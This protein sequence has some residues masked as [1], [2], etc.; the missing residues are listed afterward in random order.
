[1]KIRVVCSCF[2][3]QMESGTLITW[4]FQLTALPTT[5]KSIKNANLCFGLLGWV[6]CWVYKMCQPRVW[7]ICALHATATV[8]GTALPQKKK[9]DGFVSGFVQ[10]TNC[11]LSCI[12]TI[13]IYRCF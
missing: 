2:F 11:V 7:T 13:C 9:Q 3:Y 4:G 6:Q 10:A 8:P 1:M 5:E 12:F